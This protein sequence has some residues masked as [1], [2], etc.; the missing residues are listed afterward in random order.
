[1]SGGSL[2]YIEYN[3]ETVSGTIKDRAREDYLL[4][5]LAG[6]LDELKEILHAVEWDFSGD[7][8]LS[9][10]DRNK[11]ENFVGKHRELDYAVNDAVR[12]RNELTRLIK[13]C[14]GTP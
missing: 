5:A 8:S 6:R 12:I 11:I 4:L 9:Q 2:D 1:L 10:E 13:K 14:G 3:L 7:E